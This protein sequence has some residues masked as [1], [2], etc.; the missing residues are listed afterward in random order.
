MG[1]PK[2]EAKLINNALKYFRNTNKKN[3]EF[4]GKIFGT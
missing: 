3:Y 1:F 2:E 4:F